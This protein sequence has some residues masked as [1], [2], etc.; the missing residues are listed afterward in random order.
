MR[1][2][3]NS[4]GGQERTKKRERDKNLDLSWPKQGHDSGF[5]MIERFNYQLIP[6]DFAWFHPGLTGYMVRNQYGEEGSC[7]Q[8]MIRSGLIISTSVSMTLV[9]GWGILKG[10]EAL[11]R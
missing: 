11:T 8:L 9:A 2:F 3:R 7:N 10:L 4:S 6:K 1:I 5:K